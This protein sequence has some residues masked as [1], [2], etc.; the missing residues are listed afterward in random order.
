MYFDTDI[1]ASFW[2]W[3][4]RKLV[5]IMALLIVYI[6]LLQ[7]SIFL[8]FCSSMHHVWAAL[9]TPFGQ[10]DVIIDMTS[11]R[12]R[13]LDIAVWS[14]L[15]S[16][17]CE[18]RTLEWPQGR[19]QW[20]SNNGQTNGQMNKPKHEQMKNTPTNKRMDEVTKAQISFV[21]WCKAA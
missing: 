11:W 8:L 17:Y 14:T 15:Q 1:M 13:L 12:R 9:A 19:K 6:D 3:R 2:L 10:V 18:G 21:C 4:N 5:S 16:R 20:R 7:S